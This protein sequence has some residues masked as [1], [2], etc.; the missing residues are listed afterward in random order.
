M[1]ANV[2]LD[3]TTQDEEIPNAKDFNQYDVQ[4][5]LQADNSV[6]QD[7]TVPLGTFEW[8]F[9]GVLPGDYIAAVSIMDSQGN[10]GAPE[11]TAAFTVPPEATAPVPVTLTVTLG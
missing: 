2:I 6:V 10:V 7:A 1:A 5:R 11:V 8:T 9:F 4:I 3:W